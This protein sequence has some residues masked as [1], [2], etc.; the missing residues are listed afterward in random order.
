[1]SLFSTPAERSSICSSDRLVNSVSSLNVANILSHKPL[2]SLFSFLK[3]RMD[4]FGKKTL[5]IEKRYLKKGELIGE[6]ALKTT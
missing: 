3:A 2:Y 5:F 1:M 4:T 6:N